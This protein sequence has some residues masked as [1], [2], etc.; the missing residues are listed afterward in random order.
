MI[1]ATTAKLQGRVV[2]DVLSRPA[3]RPIRR[4]GRRALSPVALRVQRVVVVVVGWV[5]SAVVATFG[6]T[7]RPCVEASLVP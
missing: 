6:D 4:D 5:M 1:T 3:S 2:L 7:A